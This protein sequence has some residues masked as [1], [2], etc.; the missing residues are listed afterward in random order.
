[1]FCSTVKQQTSKRSYVLAK[2][3]PYPAGVNDCYNVTKY[4]MSHAGEFGGDAT[5]IVVA[6]DSAG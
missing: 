4:V 6:G 5:R 2:V 3:K 1:M